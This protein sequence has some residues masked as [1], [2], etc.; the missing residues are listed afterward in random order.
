[1]EVG[2]LLQ[3][4]GQAEFFEGRRF[5]RNDSEHRVEAALLAIGVRSKAPNSRKV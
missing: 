1:M 5:F 4:I 3:L 2:V